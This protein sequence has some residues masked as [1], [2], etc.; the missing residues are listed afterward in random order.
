MG[1]F[2]R[3]KL[4][5]ILEK[6]LKVENKVGNVHVKEDK[7]RRPTKER[8]DILRVYKFKIIITLRISGI[9]RTSIQTSVFF[10]VKSELIPF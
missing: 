7:I 10:Q 1:R 3:L 5:I 4:I 6:L 8:K 9:N 2:N